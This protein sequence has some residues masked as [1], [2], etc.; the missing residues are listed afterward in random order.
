MYTHMHAIR[1]CVC[2]CVCVVL[3]TI[4]LSKVLGFYLNKE[5][6]GLLEYKFLLKE[7]PK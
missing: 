6:L 5:M 7:N 1:V 3:I 4:S 2:V